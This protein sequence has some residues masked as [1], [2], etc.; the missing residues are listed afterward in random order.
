[1]MPQPVERETVMNMERTRYLLDKVYRFRNL[2]DNSLPLSETARNL[3]NNYAAAFIQFNL[4]NRD[5][6]MSL[7]DAAKGIAPEADST[8]VVVASVAPSAIAAVEYA[9]LRDELLN[10]Y[11]RC[12]SI[13]PWDVRARKYRHDFLMENEMYDV[14]RKRL[15]EA[16]TI[17]PVNG[18]YRQMEQQ[19]NSISPKKS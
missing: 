19:L 13:M 14:A 17:D 9:K 5:K 15:D 3:M 11:D 18:L 16:L 4:A 1:V 8:G 10:K 2:G 6:L 12:V 7:K